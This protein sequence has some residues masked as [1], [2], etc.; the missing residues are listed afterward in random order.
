[1]SVTRNE[2]IGYGYELLLNSNSE[3]KLESASVYSI[4]DPVKKNEKSFNAESIDELMKREKF[5]EQH[6]LNVFLHEN[7]K[8]IEELASQGVYDMRHSGYGDVPLP[9]DIRR[10]I[11]NGEV[12][13]RVTPLIDQMY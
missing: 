6:G 1:M 5:E 9:A 11:K 2:S 7:G 8:H 10:V 4:K 12:S 13:T 3:G